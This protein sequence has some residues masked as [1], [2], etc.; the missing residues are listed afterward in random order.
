[1]TISN[2]FQEQTR[3]VREGFEVLR[4]HTDETLIGLLTALEQSHL[5]TLTTLAAAADLHTTVDLNLRSIL[6]RAS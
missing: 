1:M 6:E 5:A 2:S 4:E 3:I